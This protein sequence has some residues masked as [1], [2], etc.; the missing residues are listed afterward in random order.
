[1]T[2]E[3][4]LAIRRSLG[5]SRRQLASLM[6][7]TYE[8]LCRWENG[9]RVPSTAYAS[10]LRD[11]VRK[12]RQEETQEHWIMWAPNIR[13]VLKE[14]RSSQGLVLGSI[15]APLDPTG[16]YYVATIRLQPHAKSQLDLHG[17]IS[18]EMRD[19]RPKR[20]HLV[21]CF[22]GGDNK[23]HP[24]DHIIMFM[25]KGLAIG[26][27]HCVLCDRVT[28]K[29]TVWKLASNAGL[30]RDNADVVSFGYSVIGDKKS[31]SAASSH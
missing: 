11:L 18:V 13:S 10:K 30:K 21:G 4:I 7:T 29:L 19:S 20:L 14:V 25:K 31:V 8:T 1:M 17:L 2:S 15:H 24:T 6:G 16:R 26:A 22:V 3:E 12:E 9:H 23:T 27:D 5:L 28:E